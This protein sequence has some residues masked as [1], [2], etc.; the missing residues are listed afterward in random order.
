M[1]YSYKN[2][3]IIKEELSSKMEIIIFNNIIDV[4]EISLPGLFK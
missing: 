4:K 1:K 3:N 2:I